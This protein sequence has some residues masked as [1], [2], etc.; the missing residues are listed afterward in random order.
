MTIKDL[1]GGQRS[2]LPGLII[3]LVDRWTHTLNPEKDLKDLNI[4]PDIVREAIQ[5]L[6]ER[7]SLKKSVECL[8]GNY[9]P[10]QI[11]TQPEK[12][13][14]ADILTERGKRTRADYDFDKLFKLWQKI[15]KEGKF[16]EFMEKSGVEIYGKKS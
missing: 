14:E 9:K 4:G 12:F 11:L 10:F 16:M 6:I 5:D 13:R 3:C 15:N 7:R 1:R 8:D 2:L